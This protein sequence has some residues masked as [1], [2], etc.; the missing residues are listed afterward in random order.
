MEFCV[1]ESDCED[2][3]RLCVSRERERVVSREVDL[4]WAVESGIGGSCP[5]CWSTEFRVL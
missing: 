3:E 5:F 1:L 2:A 4:L